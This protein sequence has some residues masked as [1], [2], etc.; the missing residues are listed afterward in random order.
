MTGRPGSSRRHSIDDAQFDLLRSAAVSPW[1]NVTPATTP[2]EPLRPRQQRGVAKKNQEPHRP[3]PPIAPRKIS[4]RP[5][6]VP[7]LVRGRDSIRLA[8]PIVPAFPPKPQK[9]APLHTVKIAQAGW[10]RADRLNAQPV[11]HAYQDLLKQIEAMEL[12]SAENAEKRQMDDAAYRMGLANISDEM[13]CKQKDLIRFHTFKNEVDIFQQHLVPFIFDIRSEH[14]RQVNSSVY[15]HFNRM[16]AI[17]DMGIP[18][19]SLGEYV[20][21]ETDRIITARTKNTLYRRVRRRSAAHFIDTELI[22]RPKAS[23]SSVQPT[24]LNK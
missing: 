20:F 17:Q 18:I 14:E 16:R 21:E 8:A 1:R 9:V 3:A 22:P 19:Y 10:S 4:I 24:Q 7:W 5:V 6:K 23:L 11:V 15:R 12:E 13:V 2:V